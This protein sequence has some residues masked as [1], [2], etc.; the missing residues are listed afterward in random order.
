MESLPFLYLIGAQKA[1]TTSLAT[2]L[3][4]HPDI[5][6]ANPKEPHYFTNN[7]GK[8]VEWYQQCFSDAKTGSSV[9]LDASTSYTMARVGELS[10]VQ[11]ENPYFDVAGRIK[12]YSPNAKFIYM[13]R[14]PVSRT[15]SAYWHHVRSGD[16]KRS[17]EEAVINNLNDNNY[18]VRPSNYYLQLKLFL[19]V[20]PLDRFLIIFFEDF[21]RSHQAALDK[22]YEFAGVE[23]IALPVERAR[24]QSFIPSGL[25]RIL[26]NSFAV[27]VLK[28]VRPIIPGVIENFMKKSFTNT[29]PAIENQH[30]EILKEYFSEHNKNLAELL[31]VELNGWP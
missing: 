23:N 30:K 29:I 31:G 24:N 6:L 4:Q 22:C 28:K 8:G 18:Y 20:F 7:W 26:F 13:L 2:Y 3:Q 11:E 9:L 16:E 12:E 21:I 5:C 17:F 15:Y 14:E 10:T 27:S 25:G 1:G 19:E